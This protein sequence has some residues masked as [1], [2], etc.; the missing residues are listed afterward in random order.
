MGIKHRVTEEERKHIHIKKE[1]TYFN[2]KLSRTIKKYRAHLIE[3]IMLIF[4]IHKKQKLILKRKIKR[5]MENTV[6]F[7]YKI[8]MNIPVKPQASL[9]T[10]IMTGTI[11]VMVFLST[12]NKKNDNSLDQS[13]LLPQPLKNLRQL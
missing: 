8:F 10:P 13:W 2:N 11:S 9:Q 6:I 5:E 7:D 12:E 1:Y 3:R 4:I